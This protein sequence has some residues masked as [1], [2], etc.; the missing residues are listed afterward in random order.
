VAQPCRERLALRGQVF[1]S[2]SPQSTL[3]G[4][5]TPRGE[6]GTSPENVTEKLKK[7]AKSAFWIARV[8]SVKAGNTTGMPLATSP[9][10]RDVVSRNETGNGGDGRKGRS[11]TGGLDLP[12]VGPRRP[13]TAAGQRLTARL[14][15]LLGG[16]PRAPD[17]DRERLSADAREAAA[18]AG[19]SVASLRS[20]EHARTTEAGASRL[21][22]SL[23][24]FRFQ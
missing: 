24:N 19:R 16:F 23:R 17:R 9:S 22:L 11:G 1:A 4:T 14:R 15:P 8:L 21:A 6:C 5:A 18:G 13:R 12:G 10:G 3:F 20:N 7:S 2:C